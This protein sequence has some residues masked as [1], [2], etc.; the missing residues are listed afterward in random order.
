MKEISHQID[1]KL[2]EKLRDK[3][4]RR[5]FFWAESCA[6]I[7]K[8]LIDLRKRRGLNQKQVAEITGTKQPAI[9][10]AEQADNQSRNLSTLLSIADGLDARVRI[11]IEPAEDILWEYDDHVVADTVGEADNQFD[12]VLAANLVSTPVQASVS[13]PIQIEG[14]THPTGVLDTY[15]T[16]Q[17]AYQKTIGDN[18]APWDF[19]TATGIASPLVPLMN[20]TAIVLVPGRNSPTASSIGS[21]LHRME[22]FR[23]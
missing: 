20:K 14:L 3:S 16:V 15:S 8:Q 1:L 19:G 12:S 6:H 23:V 18:V 5:K 13:M 17:G 4:Y 9:S 2:P 22:D 11:L 10:R 21:A 7:A